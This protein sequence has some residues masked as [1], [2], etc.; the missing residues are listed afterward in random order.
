[1][2]REPEHEPRPQ[3]SYTNFGQSVIAFGAPGGDFDFP[4]TSTA[5]S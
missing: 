2:V 5:R 1:M 3:A 4:P